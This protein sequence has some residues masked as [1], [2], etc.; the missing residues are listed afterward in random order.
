MPK[1]R[2][3]TFDLGLLIIIPLLGKLYTRLNVPVNNISILMTGIDKN[4][5]FLRIFIIPYVIWYFYRVIF[6]IYLAFKDRETYYK[7]L[8]TYTLG[9]L[10]CYLIYSI[11]QTTVP[12]PS[13]AGRDLL[14][15]MVRLIYQKDNP[16]NCFPSIHSFTSFLM[17]KAIL[18]SNIKNKFNSSFVIVLSTSII[19]STLFVKQHFIVDAISA[20][21]LANLLFDFVNKY[22]FNILSP[23]LSKF[24]VFMK[25][26]KNIEN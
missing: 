12:R 6:F 9:I 21:L 5:P 17:I 14:T 26:D 3:I 4:I 15:N 2:R 25:L 22:L 7:T 16:Y 19:L 20:I 13:L 1:L 18:N 24:F 10:I 8:L 23:T 11:Y